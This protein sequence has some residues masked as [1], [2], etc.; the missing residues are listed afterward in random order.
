[1][2]AHG[3]D[4]H[5]IVLYTG[6]GLS[7]VEHLLAKINK[8]FI[9]PIHEPIQPKQQRA[10]TLTEDDIVVYSPSISSETFLTTL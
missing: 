5:K 6:I 10:R 7:T 3:I 9:V 4:K 8:G 1:M 2:Y